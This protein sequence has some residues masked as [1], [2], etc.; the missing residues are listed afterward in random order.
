MAKSIDLSK[1]VYELVKEY[2]ELKGIMA[3][4]GFKDILNPVR[5][6]TI[7]RVMTIPKGAVMKGI[8]MREILS[9]FEKTDLRLSD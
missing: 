2:P 7:G 1:T 9:A 3:D 5:L 4:L 6:N 8:D